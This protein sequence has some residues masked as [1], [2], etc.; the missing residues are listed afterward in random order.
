MSSVP[1][2]GIVMTRVDVAKQTDRP[3]ANPMKLLWENF[4]DEFYKFSENQSYETF[5]AVLE[6]NYP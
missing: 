4:T 2:G 6:T 3:G 1:V 5:F